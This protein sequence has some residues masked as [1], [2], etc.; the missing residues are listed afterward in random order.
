MSSISIQNNACFAPKR[1]TLHPSQFY[2]QQLQP[3]FLT[4]IS[5]FSSVIASFFVSPSLSFPF[6]PDLLIIFFVG[7][8][9]DFVGRKELPYCSA[10]SPPALSSASAASEDHILTAAIK[11]S[12]LVGRLGG[13]TSHCSRQRHSRRK[14]ESKEQF[15][16]EEEEGEENIVC[17]H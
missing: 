8:T 7:I 13:W 9:Q 17:T 11:V 10:F 3:S 5:F 15:I 14:Q 2:V 4:N 6:L 16:M 12:L 1:I